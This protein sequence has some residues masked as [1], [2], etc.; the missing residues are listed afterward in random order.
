MTTYVIDTNV[1]LHDCQSIFKFEEHEVVIPMT[2]IEEIDHFKKEMNELGRNARHFSRLM[3]ELREKGSLSEGVTI[4][5][6]GGVLRV[7]FCTKEAQALMPSDMDMKVADNRILA[8]ALDVRNENTVLV[9]QD[10]NLR[11]KADSLGLPAETYENQAVDLNDMYTGTR[12]LEVDSEILNTIYQDHQ[13]SLQALSIEEPMPNECLTLQSSQNPKQAVLCR[14]NAAMK[15]LRQLP[16]DMTTFGLTP[17]SA[18]QQYALD[19]LLDP[20]V[21]L[22]TLIGKAGCGKTL[23]ALAAG[24]HGVMESKQYK[25]LLL[26]K[27]VTSMGNSNQLGF[28]PGDLTEKLNPWLASYTDN[29]DLLMGKKPLAPRSEKGRKSKKAQEE[30]EEKQAG[31]VSASQELAEQGYM[32]RGSLEHLRGR[33]LPYQYI[34]CDEVQNTTPQVIKTI[35]T[36]AGEGTKVVLLGDISQIDS[37]YLSAENNGLVFVAE[38]FKQ[39]TLSGHMMLKKSERS[40]LAE[41]ASELL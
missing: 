4:N 36:R 3:D 32:E 26:L 38:R 15:E 37:P 14:Y 40:K 35:I 19:L 21:P 11:I 39:D 23:C 1:I 2:V 5:E 30:W 7:A 41:R 29:I 18:E 25:K 10:T 33:S 16:Q 6:L 8:R 17:R 24:L 13:I 27:P 9:S 28:L 34:I 22:V 31:V 12:V 20:D